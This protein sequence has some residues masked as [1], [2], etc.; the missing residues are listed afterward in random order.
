MSLPRRIPHTPSNS[1]STP[2][3]REN[4]KGSPTA[5][6]RPISLDDVDYLGKASS[7]VF[8]RGRRIVLVGGS[9]LG[10]TTWAAQWPKPI[11]VCD[12]QERGLEDLKVK[13]LVDRSIMVAPAMQ[14]WNAVMKVCSQLAYDTHSYQTAVFEGITGFEQ[15]CFRYCCA[16]DYNNNW[17]KYREGFYNFSNGPK[18]AAKKYWPEFL[19]RLE[20][21]ANRGIHVILTGHT[22]V[23]TKNTTSEEFDAE[24]TYCD[25]ETWAITH[26]WAEAILVVTLHST[27]T[28]GKVVSEPS[29]VIHCE[30]RSEYDGGNRYGITVPIQCG[31]DGFTGYSNFCRAAGIDTATGFFK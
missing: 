17:T 21:M 28:D 9:K 26:R 7:E 13:G 2:A 25:K 3:P 30:K 16:E 20:T 19:D 8:Q 6:P 15:L 23:K 27:V 29:R 12:Y 14:S 31:D 4:Q 5:P 18:T 10:K 22:S 1:N 11:F 24:V